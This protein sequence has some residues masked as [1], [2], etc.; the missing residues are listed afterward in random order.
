MNVL[1]DAGWVAKISDFGLARHR[2]ETRSSMSSKSSGG[3]GTF[4]WQAPETFDDEF[5][6]KTDVYR[7]VFSAKSQTS[8]HGAKPTRANSFG[9]LFNSF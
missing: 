1:L 3:G 8:K 4:R 2:D 7:C 9:G 5:G 6:E